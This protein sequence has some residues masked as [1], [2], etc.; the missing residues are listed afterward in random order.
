[1]TTFG[2]AGNDTFFLVAATTG[3]LDGLG[4]TDIL[5]F[6]TE[7]QSNYIITQGS[8]GSVLVDSVSSASG[9]GLH[10]TL[11][12]IERLVFTGSSVDLTTLFA[13]APTDTTPPS[14]SGLSPAAQAT[15]V[16]VDSNIV[17]TFSESIQRGTGNIVIKGPGGA[18]VA[19][20]DAATSTNLSLSGSTLTINPT[21][22]L[23]AGTAY[24]VEL[25]AGSIKDL[26][27]NNFAGNGSYGFTT[28]NPTITGGAGND[29]LSGTAQNETISGG[30]GR[31]RIDGGAGNDAIDGGTGL[32]TAVY[33]GARTSFTV[34]KTTSG[35]TVTDNAGTAGT[36]TLTSVERIQFTDGILAI[37]IGTFQTAGEAYRIYRAAFAR[38]PDNGGLKYWIDQMD[39]NGQSDQLVAHNFIVSAEFQSLYGA[40]PTHSQLVTAMYQNVLNRAPDQ[41]GFDYWKGLLDNNQITPEQLLINFSESNENVTAVGSAINSGIWLV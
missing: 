3:T 31:D 11:Q 33:A 8:G 9:G 6:G 1:M 36:D 21:T 20:Y 25:P 29:T 5:D 37:D 34:T 17:V 16:A 32:D 41:S 39:N 28:A 24:T 12:N 13:P 35:F 30:D 18:T 22:N 14:I 15:Q 38:T 26:A 40:N 4:G 27:G 7:P 19:S 10:V 23:G 2:T